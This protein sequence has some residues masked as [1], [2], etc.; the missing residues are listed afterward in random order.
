MKS[1]RGS[2]PGCKA[3]GGA[4]FVGG[5]IYPGAAAHTPDSTGFKSLGPDTKVIQEKTLQPRK[6][7]R[8]SFQWR[9][10]VVVGKGQKFSSGATTWR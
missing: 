8:L 7:S 3:G 9:C 1:R 2:L 10:G 5:A 6:Y 4:G